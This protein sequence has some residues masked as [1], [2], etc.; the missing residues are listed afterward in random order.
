[1]LLRRRNESAVYFEEPV[2]VTETL[3]WIAARNARGGSKLTLFAL[4][5]HAV[6]RVLHEHPRL[7]RFVSGR[8]LYQRDGVWLAFTVKKSMEAGAPLAVVKRRFEPGESLDALLAD[9]AGR[10]TEAR[11]DKV[12]YADREMDLLLRVPRLALMGLV[13]VVEVADFFGL[14]PAKFIENDPFFSSAF[15]TNLGSVG[16]G[17]AYHH[18]YEYGNIPVFCTLGRV[19]DEVVARD[20]RPVVR[21]IARVKY[22]YDERI[23][24]GFNAIRALRRVTAYVER[25]EQLASESESESGSPGAGGT[26]GTTH[27]RANGSNG[28]E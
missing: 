23:E 8:R 3:A 4:W 6:A 22:S 27:A 10:V 20:G 1:M 2:D 7:N 14:L 9:L 17:A 16:G 24:D 28:A 13:R 25:P 12:S 26:N 5:V 18:L 19:G 15:M 21:T 11:S